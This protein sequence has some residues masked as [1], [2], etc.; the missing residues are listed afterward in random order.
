MVEAHE[1][2]SLR[3]LR[4]PERGEPLFSLPYKTSDTDQARRTVAWHLIGGLGVGAL[5]TLE[6]GEPQKH[7]KKMR[8][9]PPAT[10]L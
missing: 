3:D 7:R 5:G 6:G 10:P 2:E 1:T 8:Y 4:D 9:V